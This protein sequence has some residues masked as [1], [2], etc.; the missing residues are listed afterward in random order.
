M[1]LQ[2]ALLPIFMGAFGKCAHL[3]ALLQCHDALTT[4][5][6]QCL[7]AVADTLAG[8]V[9]TASA[10]EASVIETCLLQSQAE[11]VKDL[12]AFVISRE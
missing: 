10:T 3:Q 4:A 2:A 6:L 1:V 8:D 5:A 7:P 9:Q 11:L 12:Q